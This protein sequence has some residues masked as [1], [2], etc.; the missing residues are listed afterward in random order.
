[1]SPVA[2]VETRLGTGSPRVVKLGRIVIGAV[3]LVGLVFYLFNPLAD[4]GSP[5]YAAGVLF[6]LALGASLVA[7]FESIVTTSVTIRPEGVTFQYMW[8][9][10]FSPWSSLSH[11]D[12]E[13]PAPWLQVREFV[14]RDSPGS[15]ARYHLVSTVQE[16]AILAR[17]SSGKDPR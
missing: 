8:Y 10:R 7:I 5:R 3:W 16:A 15:R 1:M 2:E 4:L 12:R 6:P 11:N 14:Q 9:Q 13:Q 17:M